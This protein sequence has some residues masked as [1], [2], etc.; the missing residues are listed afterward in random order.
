MCKIND[1]YKLSTNLINIDA[2][3]VR[4]RKICYVFCRISELNYQ[5]NFCFPNALPKIG[6]S[7]PCRSLSGDIESLL[8][9]NSSLKNKIYSYILKPQLH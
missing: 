1:F 9:T 7:L 4:V 8:T 3:F 2:P 5:I 6:Q